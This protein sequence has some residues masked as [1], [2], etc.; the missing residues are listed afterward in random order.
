MFKLGFFLIAAISLT[1]LGG[2]VPSHCSTL[3]FDRGLPIY[4]PDQPNLNK[5]A[6]DNRS[7]NRLYQD[8]GTTLPTEY[9]I[10]GD[11]F[12][13]GQTGQT[14]HIDTLRI[15][16]TE[17]LPLTMV[18]NGNIQV[19]MGP[20]GGPITS[21]TPV[22]TT[23]TW[24]PVKYSNNAYYQTVE[25]GWRQLLQ[26]DVALNMNINGGEKYWFFVDGTFYSP[27]NKHYYSN[28]LHASNA[29]LSNATEEGADGIFHWLDLNGGNPTQI[30]DQASILPGDL[31]GDGNLQ[32]FGEA[33]PVPSTLLL[34]GSG[35]LGL[36]GWRR[37]RKS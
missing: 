22:S 10:P 31:G 33:V 8:L 20:A 3:L 18:A 5:R 14:Y 1:F 17:G 23:Y 9:K 12:T 29:G 21:L 4:N 34:L 37:F 30:F 19:W 15:W 36:T 24:T 7:N 32:I 16:A 26:V 25:G 11:D 13:I 27:I 28:N 2:V 6:G 35:L